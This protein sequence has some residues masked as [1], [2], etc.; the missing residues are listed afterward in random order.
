MCGVSRRNYNY[1]SVL[2]FMKEGKVWYSSSTFVAVFAVHFQRSFFPVVTNHNG[3]IALPLITALA[4]TCRWNSLNRDRLLHKKVPFLLGIT[5]ITTPLRWTSA[6]LI[7][8][9]IF[10]IPPSGNCPIQN[11]LQALHLCIKKNHK[12]HIIFWFTRIQC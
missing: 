6:L 5:S 9:I 3:R 12:C 2:M 7:G 8:A 1:A 10:A 4:F 11:M